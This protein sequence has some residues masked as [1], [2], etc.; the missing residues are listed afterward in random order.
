LPVALANFAAKKSP[1]ARSLP[2]E[3]LA[4][5]GSSIAIRP[6]A[7]DHQSEIPNHKFPVTRPTFEPLAP[8]E[9]VANN[10]GSLLSYLRLMR[11][12]NVFTAISD[13]GMG[14]AFTRDWQKPFGVSDAL[15]LACLAGASALL[16]TAGM[17]LNDLFDYDIDLQERPSRPLPSGRISLGTAR[18]L[19]FTLLV[20]GVLLGWLAGLAYSSR[21]DAS[22]PWRSGVIATALAGCIL[23]YD[24]FLKRTPLGSL[25]MGACRFLNVLLGMSVAGA[26]IARPLGFSAAELFAAA[27]IGVYV[28]GIT[29]FARSE[30]G[31]SSRISLVAGLLTMLAGIGLL[32]YSLSDRTDLKFQL[33]HMWLLLALLLF[34][35]VRRGAAALKEPSPERV[36]AT[37]KQAIMSL[38]VFDAAV[39]IAVAPTPYALGVLALLAPAVLLGQWV[40]ST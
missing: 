20:I 21:V 27:G 9:A 28:V 10:R 6:P 32:G 25:G 7:L 1:G 35:T 22:I 39:C 14:F 24:G 23:L 34:P 3:Y 13:V 30:A 2:P 40:Y 17:V 8:H 15:L 38:I 26:W 19:G 36:Q 31:E 11:L 37:V 16:Y 12:P 29:W 5:H 18:A 4:G 33:T